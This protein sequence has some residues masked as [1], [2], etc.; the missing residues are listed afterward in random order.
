M[1]SSMLAFS[2]DATT[3]KRV[4]NFLHLFDVRLNFLHL[5]DVNALSQEKHTYIRA[6][7]LLRTL[8]GNDR[9]R[10]LRALTRSL[11]LISI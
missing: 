8:G 1:T 4:L 5:F 9:P 7:K 10:D 2:D 3:Q 6:G 11:Q